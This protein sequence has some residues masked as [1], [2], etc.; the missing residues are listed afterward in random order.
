MLRHGTRANDLSNDVSGWL[1]ISPDITE[2]LSFTEGTI[3]SSEVLP[4]HL[5]G[6]NE[7]TENE[8]QHLTA[9]ESAEATVLQS[10]SPD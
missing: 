3:M 9:A 7:A 5:L 8:T 10:V 4:V 6:P 1:P 2:H